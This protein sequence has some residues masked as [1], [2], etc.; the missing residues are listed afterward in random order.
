MGSATNLHAT[1]FRSILEISRTHIK[2]W[3]AKR[4]RTSRLVVTLVRFRNLP[5][6]GSV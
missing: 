4:A 6:K 1:E 2:G 5:E 3:E